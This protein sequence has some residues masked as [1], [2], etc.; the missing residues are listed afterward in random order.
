MKARYIVIILVI[1][2]LVRL[3]MMEWTLENVKVLLNGILGG[4]ILAYFVI[5]WSG[6]D[7]R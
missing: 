5:A 2:F 4:A 3:A 7:E 6:K 1:L